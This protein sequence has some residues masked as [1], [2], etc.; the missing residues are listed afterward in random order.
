LN[1]SKSVKARMVNLDTYFVIAAIYA[2]S[3]VC[4]LVRDAASRLSNAM[5]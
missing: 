2:M 3:F 5:F 4:L 1:L